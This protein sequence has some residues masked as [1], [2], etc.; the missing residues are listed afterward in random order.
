MQKGMETAKRKF[1]RNGQIFTLYQLDQI[2]GLPER[3]WERL[4]FSI[5]VLLE[6]VLRSMPDAQAGDIARRLA[7]WQPQETSRQ[8]IPFFPGRVVLQDFTGVPVMNDLAAMRS[9]LLARGGDPGTVN[10]AIWVDLVIDHSIMVNEY[11]HPG[12]LKRNTELE[13]QRNQER[14]A[15]LR[16]CEQA[17]TNFRVVPPA[18]G[19]IHQVNLEYLARALLSREE[20]GEV[21]LFP[22]TLIGTDS[23][24]TMINSLGV[25][26][27]GVGGI[28]AVAA[29]MGQPLEMLTPD[30]IGLK[31]SGTLP[32]GATPTDLTLTI[33]EL[34]RKKGVVDKFVE[35]CGP[36]LDH[37]SL[38]DRAMIANMT[39]E[40]GATMIYF[41]VDRQTLEYLRLTGKPA[42]HIALVEGYYRTQHLFRTDETPEPVF[43]DLLTL[44]LSTIEPSLA[45]PKRPQ[46]RVSLSHAQS[47]LRAALTRAKNERGYGL[48]PADLTRTARL[49]I[50]G[51]TSLV[52]H[53]FLALAAITSCTNTSN[54]TVMLA[55]GLLARNAV[56]RGLRVPAYVKTSLTPGSRVVSDYLA[57][58]GLLASLETLGFHVAGYGCATCIGNSGPLPRAVVD[59]V[60]KEKILAAAILSGN[61]N[62]EG[63]VSPYTQ[64]N[65]LASPP[66]VVAYA[67][68]GTMN[69]QL[70]REPLGMDGA[71]NAVFLKDIWPSAAEIQ[72]L[73]HELIQPELFIAGYANVLQGSPAWNQIQPDS[74]KIYPWNDAS[75]YLQAPPFFESPG[76]SAVPADIENARVLL[77][78]GDSVTTDHISP[79][80]DIP[81]DS[82]AGRYLLEHGEQA[83]NFNSFGAR[84]GND[85]VMARGTFA[86]IRL[87]NLLV[88]GVEGGITCHL[89]DGEHMSVFEA[90]QKYQ[91]EGVP[92]LV[93]AGKEYGTG[94]SRDWAAKG[95]LLLGVKAILAESFERI[96]RA[97]LAGMGVL[98]LEF[99]PGQNAA[100]LGL[101]GTERYTLQNLT[102]LQ[103]GKRVA[104]TATRAD[105]MR[106]EFAVTMR[107]N[108]DMEAQ[109]FKDGGIMATILLGLS[110]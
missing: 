70:E 11:G 25:A 69:I 102:P 45:G 82:T 55:A 76:K 16:W 56:R 62:F 37:L 81:V 6:G 46:D 57:R 60:E 14:Y 74:G 50:H 4:P 110:K 91:M 92:L 95:P 84:R 72:H 44:D 33:I 39:P 1:E 78:L 9:A 26:G 61:R 98:P 38:A 58:S 29:M 47:N 103:P 7:T 10:P 67:L 66:L 40:C 13:F 52:G 71:G 75:T 80:G 77:L 31:L 107:I 59:V 100:S 3:Y 89:P 5:R 101:D 83:A 51:Q 54:P 41:P 28:E 79:A 12:A 24:T 17:F 8:V 34:L 20:N 96:H 19:I 105:G 22:E 73:L 87:K 42:S 65:Y 64:I 32:E 90:A 68:A 21:C 48:A 2:P 35:V 36:G 86:N 99:L 109:Y 15:F 108:T 104:V 27:W 106:V 49:D 18:T 94:S 63:R 23:H 30:V 88:P 43:S 97:N 93:I 53:G 85:Q